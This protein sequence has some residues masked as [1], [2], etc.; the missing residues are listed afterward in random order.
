MNLFGFYEDKE[1][2]DHDVE[3]LLNELAVTIQSRGVDHQNA[4]WAIR[5]V[6]KNGGKS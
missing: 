1:Q 4:W 2:L 3:Q 5:R 6:A